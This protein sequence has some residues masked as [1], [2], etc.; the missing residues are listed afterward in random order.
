MSLSRSK[1]RQISFQLLFAAAFQP[2][3]E[4]NA[5][6][7]ELIEE[8]DEEK[9]KDSAYIRKTFCGARDFIPEAKALIEEKSEGWKLSRLSKVTFT[10]LL[11][12][13]YEIRCTDLPERIAINEAVELAKVFDEE[14]AP[15]FINGVLGAIVGTDK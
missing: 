13:L 8:C 5:L 3:A 4:T 6:F 14:K 7:E 1:E 15:K 10:I 9:A 12:A 2:E 11:L